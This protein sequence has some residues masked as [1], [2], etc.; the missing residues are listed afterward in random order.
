M[1]PYFNSLGTCPLA[2]MM[3]PEKPLSKRKLAKLHRTAVKSAARI[4]Q[5]R[6]EDRARRGGGM[7]LKFLF[8]AM[9]GRAEKKAKGI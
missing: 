7:L 6:T 3:L 2:R 1:S 5:S 4:S 9:V 8:I